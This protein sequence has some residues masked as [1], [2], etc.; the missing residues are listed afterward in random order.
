M[1]GTNP[2]QLRES[3]DIAALDAAGIDASTLDFDKAK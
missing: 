3:E 1:P 2:L